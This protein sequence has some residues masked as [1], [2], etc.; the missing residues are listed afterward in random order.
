M[1]VQIPIVIIVNGTGIMGSVGG[2]G[3]VVF[4]VFDGGV[5]QIPASGTIEGGH[6]VKQTSP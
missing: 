2:T 4:V 6:W 3:V 5:T 1:Q